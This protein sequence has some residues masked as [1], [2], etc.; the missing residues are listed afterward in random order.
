ME[1]QNKNCALRRL[2]EL[3]SRVMCN[4]SG[5]GSS[6]CLLDSD[7][8]AAA[9]FEARVAVIAANGAIENEAASDE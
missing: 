6:R 9:E 1:T 2:L 5:K 7:Y 3:V 8:R 4:Q